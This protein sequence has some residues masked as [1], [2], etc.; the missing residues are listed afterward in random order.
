MIRK[1]I[2][3]LGVALI[4]AAIVWYTF[5]YLAIHTGPEGRTVDWLGRE[6]L[7]APLILRWLGIGEWRGPGTFLFDAVT[8]LGSIALGAIMAAFGF[9][10]RTMRTRS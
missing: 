9:R 4:V 6:I 7:P 10:K 2:G 5:L 1:A 8:F 3:I